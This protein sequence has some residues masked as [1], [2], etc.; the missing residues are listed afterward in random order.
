MLDAIKSR[1]WTYFDIVEDDNT[2][3]M[4]KVYEEKG[5]RIQ[6]RRKTMQTV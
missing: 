5:S 1:V 6:Q 2:K 4:C 3:A